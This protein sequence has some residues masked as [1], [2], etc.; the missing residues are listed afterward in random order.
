MG[1]VRNQYVGK[2]ASGWKFQVLEWMTFFKFMSVAVDPNDVGYVAYLTAN[3]ATLR[4]M[5][6]ARF[7]SAWKFETVD[8]T[9]EVSTDHMITLRIGR[10]DVLGA[11]HMVRIK[12][13][14]AY[15]LRY[16][17]KQSF[18]NKA[19]KALFGSGGTALK[20][21]D[22]GPRRPDAYVSPPRM[23]AREALPSLGNCD[24]RV[25][26]TKVVAFDVS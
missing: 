17:N 12:A 5:A 10:N 26:V 13:T 25:S 2:D 4:N 23:T 21:D 20:A 1:V 19:E 7:N 8:S 3:G 22:A 15:E 16:A 11:L 24:E 18:T 14:G 9:P 6:L